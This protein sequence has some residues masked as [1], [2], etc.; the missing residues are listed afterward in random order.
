[1]I[2]VLATS[3]MHMH[4][5][6]ILYFTLKSFQNRITNDEVAIAMRILI[7]SVRVK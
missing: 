5:I 7:G 1:M 6:I 2:I 4:C 3:H